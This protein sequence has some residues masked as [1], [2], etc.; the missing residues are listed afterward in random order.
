ML[1]L[2][3]VVPEEPEGIPTRAVLLLKQEKEFTRQTGGDKVLGR[4]RC[5]GWQKGE[6]GTQ[7][8]LLPP[9]S[10]VIEGRKRQRQAQGENTSPTSALPPGASCS[11]TAS[12]H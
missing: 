9:S 1:G 4:L 11:H 5:S 10:E 7:R 12:G 6:Q 2:H 8:D 3:R